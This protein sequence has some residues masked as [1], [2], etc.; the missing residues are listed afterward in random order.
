MLGLIPATQLQRIH[1]IRTDALHMFC[2]EKKFLIYLKKVYV[3]TCEKEK[4]RHL[5]LMNGNRVIVN[6]ECYMK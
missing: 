1:I 4:K 6:M 2:K 5:S 3:V